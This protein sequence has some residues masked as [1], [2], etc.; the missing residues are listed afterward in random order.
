MNRGVVRLSKKLNTYGNT[1]VVDH[2]LGL[3]TMYM[4]LSKREVVEGQLVL[5]GQEIGKSGQTGYAEMPHLHVSIRI[6]G[7]S[8]DPMK[9]M[10]FFK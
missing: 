1:V 7:I 10:D 3:M 8:I 5:R 2:G 6:A 9:F 4:H